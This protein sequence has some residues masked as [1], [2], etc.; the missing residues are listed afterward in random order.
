MVAHSTL[1]GSD[2]HETKGVSSASADTVATAVSSA[3]VWRKIPAASI[4][5]TSIFTMNKEYIHT[6]FVD[7]STAE[8]IY[9]T[10]P[11]TGTLTKV[12][13]TLS[14]AITTADSIVLVK[15]NSGG[16]AATITVAFTASAPGTQ[17]TAT[18]TTNNTFIV[19]DKLTIETDGA[20]STASR[21][22]IVF[23]FTV[24]G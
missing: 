6:E 15:N 22:Q 5:T 20:S 10:V 4:D 14:A 11:F 23:V 7:V 1:T 18:V 12:Y 3:T 21:A 16:T 9:V 8:K 2:L 24:T 17:F 19:G 13:L